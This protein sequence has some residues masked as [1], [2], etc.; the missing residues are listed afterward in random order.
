[1]TKDAIRGGGKQMGDRGYEFNNSENR[2]IRKLSQAM[3]YLSV[4]FIALGLAYILSGALFAWRTKSFLPFINSSFL[5]FIAVLF[6]CWTGE[7]AT[8]FKSIVETHGS[9]IDSLLHA[10][11]ELRKLF[12]LQFGLTLLMLVTVIASAIA[13]L[14][15]PI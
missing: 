15:R 7:A 4:A 5:G 11:K 6:G 12:S 13:P 10:L 9:D 3:R 1:M 8:D 14:L 2:I